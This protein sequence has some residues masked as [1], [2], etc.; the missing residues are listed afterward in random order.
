MGPGHGP[1]R[2]SRGLLRG[3]EPGGLRARF[4]EHLQRDVLGFWERALDEEAGGF[5]TDLD[6]RGRPRGPQTRFLV[7][8]A[9]LVWSF[10]AAHRAGFGRGRYLHL[11]TR[12]AE[13]LEWFW[14]RRH[15]GWCMEVD[16]WGRVTDPGKRLYGQTFAIYATAELAL[17]SG[18]QEVRDR[19]LEGLRLLDERGRAP[20]GAFATE[21]S[22]DWA[23]IGDPGPD[24][25]SHIHLME[26]LVPVVE[27]TGERGHRELLRWSRD[28]LGDRMTAPTEDGG[29]RVIDRLDGE[30]RPLPEPDGMAEIYGHAIE[31][32]WLLHQ[33]AESLEEP[34]ER[35]LG[36]SRPLAERVLAV[37]MDR[38]F[39]GLAFRGT[40]ERGPTAWR[41]VWWTQAE[42][43]VGFLRLHRETGDERFHQAFVALAEWV[44]RRQGDPRYGEWFAILS[45]RGRVRDG[46]KGYKWKSAYHTTRACLEVIRLLGQETPRP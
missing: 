12:A 8:V 18:S 21:W 5:F 14:D 4:A 44:L 31:L 43:L 17:A 24:P 10:A 22:E 13:T 16:R 7:H 6:R 29:R 3:T 27:L 20:H 2:L 36:V 19:A 1:D 37:A 9:R 26:A 28:L 42:G 45:R 15:G 39:G 35:T 23:P 46:R 41:K 32:A 33:A 34:A 25:N 40:A 38:R 11:S 30:W